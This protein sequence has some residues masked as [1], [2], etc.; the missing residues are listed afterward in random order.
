MIGR[1]RAGGE[2]QHVAPFYG[3]KTLYAVA[4]EPGSGSITPIDPRTGRPGRPIPIDDG[5]NMYDTPD[6][7]YAIV[8]QE[9]YTV[10]PSTTRTPGSCTIRWRSPHSGAPT[11]WTS[12]PMAQAARQL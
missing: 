2:P 1:F 9:A 5:Y 7:R 10:W 12:P 8:V 6:G 11:R 3:L 4:D